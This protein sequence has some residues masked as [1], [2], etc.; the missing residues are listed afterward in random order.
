[1]YDTTGMRYFTNEHIKWQNLDKIYEVKDTKT[2]LEKMRG[3]I[4]NLRINEIENENGKGIKI[5]GSLPK[6][7]FGNNIEV[8][9][10]QE[11]K[12]AIEKLSDTL[13][14][15]IEN[16]KMTRIDIADNFIME[17]RVKDY[18]NCLDELSRFT[19]GYRDNSLYFSTYKLELIIYD[20]LREMSR[21]RQ[22]IPEQCIQYKGRI[23]RYEMRILR[24]IK[25]IFGKE[26]YLRDLSDERFYVELIKKWK[27]Y[28]FQIT[29]KNKIKFN[30]MALSTVKTFENQ[31]LLIAINTL[32]ND[33]VFNLIELS[34]SDLGK[35]KNQ[36]IKRLKDKIRNI[37]TCKELTEINPL[38]RELDNK[39]RYANLHYR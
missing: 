23:L 35:H 4:G 21:K 13:C 38:I 34:R 36:K 26:V 30:E 19:K 3:N 18:Q 1:M 32:G 25:G 31:L 10:R 11:T 27:E 29:K 2:G 7:F 24:N 17:S 6:Y 39:I 37:Q 5:F 12:Q 22:A 14:L 33:E 16:S 15:K 20:K 8:L 28:Y 9:T